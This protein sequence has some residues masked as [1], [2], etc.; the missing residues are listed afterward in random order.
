MEATRLKDFGFAAA[1]RTRRFGTAMRH[2]PT[3]GRHRSGFAVNSGNA[4]GCPIHD[5]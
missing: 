2:G 5:R 3:M 1:R 4:G